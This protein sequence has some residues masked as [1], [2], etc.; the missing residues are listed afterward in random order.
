MIH[1]TVDPG[2]PKSGVDNET[3]EALRKAYAQTELLL[4]SI[5]S[6]LIG[7]NQNG[8]VTHWNAVAEK[9]FGIAAREVMNRPFA[10]CGIKWDFATVL[11][12]IQECRSKG[13][14]LRLSDLVFERQNGEKRFVGFTLIPLRQDPEGHMEYILYGADITHRKQIEEL[15]NEFISTVSHELRSPLTIIREGVSQV[16]EG[17]LGQVN[18]D[19]KRF[20]SIALE[21][22]DRLKR[23]VDDLL[24]I[25]KI[26][27]GRLELRREWVNMVSLVKGVS[28]AFQLQAKKKGLKLKTELPKGRL[29]IHVDKDRTVQVFNNLVSNALKFTEKGRIGILVIDQGNEIECR[30]SDTGIGI[31][32]ADL[33]KAF[34]KFQQFSQITSQA[35]KGTGLGLAISKGIVESQGGHIRVESELGKGTEVIFTLPKTTARENE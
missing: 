28:L 6:I 18:K 27:A 11:A 29:E 8:L 17:I 12:G 20:L 13:S 33:S 9:T 14:P 24:D 26:E 32:Q 5:T 16:L 22:I 1:E 10:Q 2:T 15:K 30:V 25:S 4:S 19:Q 34:G 35:E 21:G 7:I 23:I 3:Q 31:A